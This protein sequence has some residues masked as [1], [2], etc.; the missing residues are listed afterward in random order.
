[1]A[2]STKWR[3]YVT[4]SNGG[5]WTGFQELEFMVDWVD[6]VDGTTI[7]TSSPHYS[8]R[9]PSLAFDGLSSVC[10]FS[11][12]PCWIAIELPS[13]V[14]IIQYSI[15]PESGRAPKT[16][17]VD[18]WDGSQWV[19]ADTRSDVTLWNTI[20]PRRYTVGVYDIPKSVWRLNITAN[21]GDTQNY[22][23]FKEM[24]FMVGGVN[25]VVNTFLAST[26]FYSGR[27][28]SA[29]FDNNI[30][31]FF[32]LTSLPA[33]LQMEFPETTDIETYSF[34]PEGYTRAPKTWTLEHWDFDTSSWIAAD[35]RTG[36]IGW[37]YDGPE[38]R[39]YTVGQYIPEKS[40]WR[41]N[42]TVNDGDT[43]A[44]EIK[45]L[46]LMIGGVD[47]TGS[48]IAWGNKEYNPAA[49]AFDN[50]SSTY[51]SSYSSRTGIISYDFLTTKDIDSYS[52]MSGNLVARSPS[53]WTLEYYDEA[54]L[55]WIV[56]DTQSLETG[57]VLNEKRT[58][59]LSIPNIST[60]RPFV[61]LFY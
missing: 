8:G 7:L 37:A 18:Y 40:R 16:W 13:S 57:W 48:G 58:Y 28:P 39:T 42:I 21:N 27:P 46:E 45:E 43:Q 25:K 24:A 4:E 3:I 23:G 38:T 34:T 59:V 14:E 47:Q 49:S 56:A 52:I 31:S 20:S 55:S 41:L 19:V 54:T 22:T 50:N 6:Q 10:T 36:E 30:S 53:A 44:V 29:A 33:W 2:A 61:N 9:P 15:L 35:S 11:S 60:S 32:T 26:G 5:S 17:H 12:L 51:W 1:M